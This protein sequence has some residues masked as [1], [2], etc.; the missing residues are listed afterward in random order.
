M[1]SGKINEDLFIWCL[2][3]ACVCHSHSRYAQHCVCTCGKLALRACVYS[4]HFMSQSSWAT[5]HLFRLILKMFLTLGAS[6]RPRVWASTSSRAARDGAC[7]QSNAVGGS[8]RLVYKTSNKHEPWSHGH[9][10]LGNICCCSALAVAMLFSLKM[11]TTSIASAL[12]HQ[13]STRSPEDI[14]GIQQPTSSFGH[15]MPPLDVCTRQTWTAPETTV[16]SGLGNHLWDVSE[17]RPVVFHTNQIDLSG[18]KQSLVQCENVLFPSSLT[19]TG[20]SQSVG[21]KVFEPQFYL[22]QS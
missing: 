4:D 20:F 14:I 1:S 16:M 8:V 17:H 22:T 15:G 7:V 19:R 9:R 13:Q 18:V 5:F 12:L 10:Q 2:I 6:F 11:P 21:C 3:K